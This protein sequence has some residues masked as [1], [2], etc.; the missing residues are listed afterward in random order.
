MIRVVIYADKTIVEK[1][2]TAT[3]TLTFTSAG[4]ST[5][6]DTVTAQVVAK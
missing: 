4:D 3:F 5:K 6:Q 2:T 1:G